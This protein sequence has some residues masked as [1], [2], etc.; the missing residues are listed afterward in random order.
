MKYLKKIET[1][2][3]LTVVR[4]RPNLVL[5]NST[6]KVLYNVIPKGVYIEHID[7]SLY[8]E[9]EWQ[10]EGFSSDVAN[11]IAVITDEARFVISKEDIGSD[12]VWSHNAALLIDKVT[13]TTSAEEAQMDFRGEKNTDFIVS[14]DDEADAAILCS[15]YVFANG[16]KGYLPALGEWRIVLDNFDEIAK[17]L[18][19]IGAEPIDN[20]NTNTYYWSSTQASKEFAW[21]V[22]VYEKRLRT[23]YK[24]E[25]SG[26][27]P[28]INKV[29]AFTTL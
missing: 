27:L 4:K 5:V 12:I 19:K 8:T 7:G 6:K 3:D 11:G 1:E 25:S 17:A 23:R 24:F 21:Y 28:W 13:T 20:S 15:E 2:E 26:T 10:I 22:Y 9:E 18:S 29:R 16:Q 14:S